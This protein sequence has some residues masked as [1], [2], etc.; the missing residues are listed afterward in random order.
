MPVGR[1]GREKREDGVPRRVY[2]ERARR[3]PPG[4]IFGARLP[5]VPCNR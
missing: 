1:D 5:W 4:S 3:L 2:K